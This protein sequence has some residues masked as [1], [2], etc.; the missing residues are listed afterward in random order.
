MARLRAARDQH[1]GLSEAAHLAQA[2]DPGDQDEVANV[3]QR[4][5]D[6]IQGT[7][8]AGPG[9]FPE[10]AEPHLVLASPAGIQTTTAQST[11][12]ASDEHTALTSGGHTSVSAGRSF[13]VSVKNAIRF[14]ALDSVIKL[15]AGRENIDLVALKKS[16]TLLA[17]LEI[18]HTANRITLTA[19]QEIQINGAGSY[20]RWSAQGIEHGTLGAWVEHAAGHSMAGPASLPVVMSEFPTST[21][22]DCVIAAAS[23]RK[24][25]VQ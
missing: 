14:F 7:G 16:I 17:K 15:V 12:L 11:H 22:K 5:N 2:Q 23:A 3:L 20:T 13:L 19:K 10:L 1:E 6:A 4:Q 25:L 18:T 8:Q 9:H 24:G 21:P